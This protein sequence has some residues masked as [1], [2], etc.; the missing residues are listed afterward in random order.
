MCGL[1]AQRRGAYSQRNYVMIFDKEGNTA[2]HIAVQ[3]G[4]LNVCCQYFVVLV[5]HSNSLAYPMACAYVRL[6]LAK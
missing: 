2:L 6:V 3:N 5:D 1:S 4:S